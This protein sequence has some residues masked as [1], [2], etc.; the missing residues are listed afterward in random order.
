MANGAKQVNFHHHKK[1]IRILNLR[2]KGMQC[3]LWTTPVNEF[4]EKLSIFIFL[5]KY[6]VANGTYLGSDSALLYLTNILTDQ[7]HLKF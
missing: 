5:F 4:I 1:C 6:S 7:L 2:I 3:C